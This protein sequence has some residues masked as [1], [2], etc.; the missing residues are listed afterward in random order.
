MQKIAVLLLMLM[1]FAPMTSF[2]AGEDKTP[3]GEKN[4]LRKKAFLAH[5]AIRKG[6]TFLR[7]TQAKDGAWGSHDP[8]VADM[9]Q[10][11][12][13]IKNFGCHD[14]VRIAC[15]AICANAL[16]AYPHRTRED[17][18]ALQQAIPMLLKHRKLAYDPGNAFNCWGYAYNLDFLTT[19]YQHPYGVPFKKEIKAAV[20]EIIGGLRKM[21]AAEGGWAY[22]TS[23]MMEGASISFITSNI[24][25]GLIKARDLGFDVP[26][27]MIEDAGK[28][29]KTMLLPNKNIMYGTYLKYSGGH[30]LEDLSCGGRTQICG[31][32]LY[33]FD[34]SFTRA[35]LIDRNRDYF[36]NVD[37]V[38]KIGNKRIIPHRDAPQNISG[39][40]LY[41]GIFYA[42]EVMTFLGKDA[43]PEDWDHLL[44]MILRNQEGEGSWWDTMCYDYGAK[45]GTGFAILC[46]ERYLAA[47]NLLDPVIE[48]PP[49]EGDEENKK[50]EEKEG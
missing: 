2:S 1:V 16:L 14:G 29:T 40:F 42:A 19:L 36:K 50:K 13:G 30:Y 34:Q 28:I 5:Q 11:G 17:E 8:V 26:K 22:Y 4:S 37:Y 24:L 39:Y 21:Q 48:E 32:S 33:R 12:F 27:G 47:N 10:L 3:D 20:P 6:L 31:L 9:A 38:E 25:L 43:R 35:D 15:T 18:Q 23:V 7:K 49:T 41:Y 46:L 44:K 45:W